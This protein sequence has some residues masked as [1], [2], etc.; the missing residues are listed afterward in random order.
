MRV[1]VSNAQRGDINQI[2]S[3]DLQP[4][5]SSLNQN[6]FSTTDTIP[7]SALVEVE[8]KAEFSV[9]KRRNGRRINSIQGFIAAGVLPSEVVQ[10]WQDRLDDANFELPSG[11]WL[12]VAGESEKKGDAEASLFATLPLTFLLAVSILV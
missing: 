3:L 6:R 10:G 4:T 9:I 11:Y 2:T 1:R 12:E 5:G 8:L 7:M